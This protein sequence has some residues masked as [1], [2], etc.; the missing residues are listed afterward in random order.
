[1]GQWWMK[2][3]IGERDKTDTVKRKRNGKKKTRESERG[4]GE[5]GT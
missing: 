2:E 5:E 3:E 4:G 1:M